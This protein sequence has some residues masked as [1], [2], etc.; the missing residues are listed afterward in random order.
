MTCVEAVLGVARVRLS[1][2]VGGRE[3]EHMYRFFRVEVRVW[4]KDVIIVGLEKR[5]VWIQVYAR[6]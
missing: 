5:H 6:C 2:C 3:R 1:A 4:S